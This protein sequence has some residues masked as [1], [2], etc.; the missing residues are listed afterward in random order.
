MKIVLGFIIS[1]VL[2]FILMP[3]LI[4]KLH[5]LKFG[6]SEREEGLAS[7]KVKSGTPTMGGI[8]F[9]VIPIVVACLV[10]YHILFNP[11]ILI[12]LVAYLGY[13][14]IGFIDDYKIVVQKCNDGLSAK[15]KF[16][17]Q[18]ALAVI[19]F[20]MYYFFS[21]HDTSVLIPIAHFNFNIGPILFFILIF[22]MFT[23][24]SNA[25]NLTDGLDGLCA[26]VS[27]IGLIPFIA[28]SL[29]NKHYDLTL[30]MASILGSLI[31]YLYFNK[32]PAKIFMG[33]T[34]SLAIGGLFAGI[35]LVERQ[36][37]VLLI[38][39]F[40]FIV[41]TLSVMLQVTH[42]RRTGKRLF[43]MAPIHHHFEALGLS[44]TKVAH[45]FY[46]WAIVFAIIGFIIGV[47]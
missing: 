10:D 28:F 33:D 9:V 46:F 14:A 3:I 38:I 35:A 44:E 18:A 36:E 43:K 27:I 8:A 34:G 26:G 2:T 24:E 47:I 41:E 19:I 1:L 6:Q 31:A 40:I 17:M 7:H 11:M 30:V 22:I 13:F 37:I 39:G 45:K 23:G 42:Y 16:L 5:D 32:Y 15:Q 12:V 25:V 21:N 4:K 20:I 29:I